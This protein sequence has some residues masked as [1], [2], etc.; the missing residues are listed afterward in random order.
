[1]DNDFERN[2]YQLLTAIDHCL[3]K[4]LNPPALIL[5]FTGIDTMSWLAG[6]DQDK[7]G[8]RFQTWVN[9]WMLKT[10]P[11]PCTALELYAA[12]CAVLRTLTPTSDLS[13]NTG[14]RELVYAF[15]SKKQ[16]ELEISIQL[17]GFSE[18]Y[19][20]IHVNEIL[21]SFREGIVAF[22]DSLNSSPERKQLFLQRAAK[23][24][25]YLDDLT[26]SS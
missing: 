13:R 14:V 24:Y 9:E 8:D 2:Y 1:M 21:S 25:H 4:G 11:L 20:A 22:L 16:R 7:V 5:I 18:K 17:N 23:Q 6:N 19:V 3:E 15:G 10:H 26:T 12:R